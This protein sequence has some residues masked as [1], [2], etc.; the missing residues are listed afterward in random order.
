MSNKPAAACPAYKTRWHATVWRQAQWALYLHLKAA[1]GLAACW[2]QNSM[3]DAAI[4][5]RA[6]S[7]QADGLFQAWHAC[8]LESLGKQGQHSVSVA[9]FQHFS[10]HPHGLFGLFLSLWSR[11]WKAHSL[12][13]AHGPGGICE[14]L[15]LLCTCNCVQR[16]Y[17]VSVNIFQKPGGPHEG[18]KLLK[19]SCLSSWVVQETLTLIRIQEHTRCRSLQRVC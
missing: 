1:F 19:Q 12:L 7:Y 14:S 13:P 16:A 5:S 11:G 9:F 6:W 17:Q 4:D 8:A 10:P 3:L 2:R 15:A 18:A